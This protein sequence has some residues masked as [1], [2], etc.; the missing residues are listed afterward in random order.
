MFR[1]NGKL[2]LTG[3]YF[4]LEG[5]KAL[6]VPTKLGQI[7]EVNSDNTTSSI[8]SW[9]SYDPA[10]GQWFTAQFSLPT[11]QLLSFS[12][13]GIAERLVAIFKEA[14]KLNPRF[15]A[16]EKELNVKATL[17]FPR[18]WGLGSSSTLINNMAEWAQADPYELLE[19]T[20]GGSG[21]DIACASAQGPVFYQ[22]V[23][24]QP[25]IQTASF[26]P[27]FKE[28]LYFVFLNQ[29]Q[30]SREG[31]ARFRAK[32]FTPK[33]LIEEIS[34]LT[35]Q[36]AICDS[37][38]ELEQLLLRHE[39]MVR[40]YLDLPR[41]QELHFRDFPGVVKSLGAWGGDY[42]LVTS[43][44]GERHTKAFFEKRGYRQVFKYIDFIIY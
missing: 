39:T 27:P 10:E 8:L 23:D 2:L 34:D 13:Q 41:A 44:E 20:F 15:L 35:D 16:D 28:N 11:L 22:L 17:E 42:V 19:K 32:G 43:R 25:I 21:Y 36:I 18:N 9:E 12:D 31:I 14:Q 33:A 37:F 26:N 3:E 4:V 30:N 5:A 6:A 24:G 40:N 7:L 1:S 29:K 38:D